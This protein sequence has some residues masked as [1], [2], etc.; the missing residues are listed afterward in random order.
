MHLGD[1]VIENGNLYCQQ[2]QT[3][4]SL[5]VCHHCSAGVSST[6]HMGQYYLHF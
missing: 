6:R 4:N 3:I 1:V 2:E 5:A